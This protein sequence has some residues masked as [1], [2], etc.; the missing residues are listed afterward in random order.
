MKGSKGL[1]FLPVMLTGMSSA[2]AQQMT[3]RMTNGV[4]LAVTERQSIIVNSRSDSMVVEGVVN[5]SAGGVDFRTGDRIL[6]LQGQRLPDL[7]TFVRTYRELAAGT[8]VSVLVARASTQHELRFR[9]P[10]R[11][12]GTTLAVAGTSGD[13]GAWTTSEATP[14]T[15]LEIVGAVFAENS[16]GMPAV[17]FRKSHPLAATLGVRVGD[18]VLALNEFPMFALRSLELRYGSVNAGAPIRLKVLRGAD[19]VV[20]QFSK[21]GS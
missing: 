21:P 6:R 17:S 4:P 18:V 2:G 10:A 16:E 7:Q 8:A 9:K 19:T 14:G 12:A 13:A 5:D 3:M 15:S 20:V 1:L 11:E